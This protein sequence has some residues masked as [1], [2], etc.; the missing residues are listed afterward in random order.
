MSPCLPGKITPSLLRDELECEAKGVCK[1][2]IMDCKKFIEE[3]IAKIRQT[4][5]KATAINA[6]SGH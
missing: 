1:G 6:L 2:I 4:V 3:Q 5:G